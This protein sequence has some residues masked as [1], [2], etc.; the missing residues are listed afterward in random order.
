MRD[1]ALRGGQVYHIESIPEVSHNT[2]TKVWLPTI[3]AP[4]DTEA[5]HKGILFSKELR[6]TTNK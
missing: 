1:I 3:G 5:A 2:Y 6:A 4:C